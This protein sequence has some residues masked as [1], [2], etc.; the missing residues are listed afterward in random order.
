MADD[1]LGDFLSSLHDTGEVQRVTG[2]VEPVGEVTAITQRVCERVA[3]GGP[4]L[5]FSAVRNSHW[6]VVTNLLGHPR[7]L[8]RAAGVTQL[9]QYAQLWGEP[10][11]EPYLTGRGLQVEPKLAPR[12]V[13]QGACQQVV[14]LGRD[15]NL[16][17][18]PALQGYE[19]E[20]HPS[21]NGGVCITPALVPGRQRLATGTF[22]V[23]DRQRLLPLWMEGDLSLRLAR[24]AQTARRQLPCAIVFGGDPLLQIAAAGGDWFE[25][26]VGLDVVG[27]LRSSSLDVVKCRSHDLEV[28]AEGELVIEGFVDPDAP[29]ELVEGL[30]TPM[31]TLSQP[32]LVP[33]LQVT[34]I[35][36]RANPVMPAMVHSPGISEADWLRT[37]V[38]DWMQPVVKRLSTQIVDWSRPR[39][40]HGLT[41]FV[42]VD[43]DRPFLAQRVSH[44]LWGLA[45]LRFVKW[46]VV[47]DADVSLAD[48]AA[49]WGTVAANVDPQRDLLLVREAADP[50]DPAAGQLGITGKIAIDATRKLREE[51]SPRVWPS[52]LRSAN[53]MWESLSKRWSELGLPDRWG[54]TP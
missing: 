8:C 43:K 20:T 52:P 34:A 3:E 18:L 29:W 38:D 7:R 42:S 17:E 1:S 28:P 36:H 50:H 27:R 10:G 11:P 25:A 54:A 21:L 49:V 23:V 33:P 47:V 41:A 30:A 26:G 31:G 40:S 46:L 22:A 19:G 14:K 15:V 32:T 48:D 51:G 39:R 53:A 2:M 9:D 13:R 5:L 24:A 4:A 45:G 35:T 12:T 6:P 16:W 44:A 37:A